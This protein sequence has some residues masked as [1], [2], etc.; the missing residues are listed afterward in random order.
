[1]ATLVQE[2][3]HCRWSSF[4]GLGQNV[5]SAIDASEGDE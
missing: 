3:S 2:N 4:Q 5:P 1:V